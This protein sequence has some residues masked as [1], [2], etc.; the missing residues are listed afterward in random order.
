MVKID[1]LA[2]LQSGACGLNQEREN[3]TEHEYFGQII[4]VDQGVLWGVEEMHYPAE[5]HVD[6]C[7]EQGGSDESED[8]GNK[9]RDERLGFVV[10]D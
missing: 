5:S 9:V 1:G 10:G 4:D 2:G 3:I 7:C 6:R 8:R